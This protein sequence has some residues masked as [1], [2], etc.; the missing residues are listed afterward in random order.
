[1][2]NSFKTEQFLICPTSVQQTHTIPN[3]NKNIALRLP[4]LIFTSL[5]SLLLSNNFF[6][7]LIGRMKRSIDHVTT[8][9]GPNKRLNS[10]ETADVGFHTKLLSVLEVYSLILVGE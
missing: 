8:S 1:L 3:T 9:G 7:I 6:S 2:G 4:S 10:E 5:G